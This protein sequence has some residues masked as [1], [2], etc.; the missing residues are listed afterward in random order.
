MTVVRI[1][2][3]ARTP[4]SLI[5]LLMSVMF[6]VVAQPGL[7]SAQAAETTSPMIDPELGGD[8]GLTEGAWNLDLIKGS[9]DAPVVLVEYASWT[10]PHCKSFH[11]QITNP[12]LEPLIEEGVL[13]FIARDFLR[14]WIDLRVAAAVRCGDIDFAAASDVLFFNQQSYSINDPD[15]VNAA[16]VTLLGEQGLTDEALKA[17]MAD[18]ELLQWLVE[19]TAEGQEVGVSGTPS[20]FING[21]VYP[22]QNL[23]DLENHI[24]TLAAAQ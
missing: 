12:V 21:E 1:A 23:A 10:C 9:V 3:W 19:R 24:R 11:E 15:A 8:G 16:I 17:C 7:A 6:S 22:L 14:N 13:R 20:I 5:G 18:T 4:L 2:P